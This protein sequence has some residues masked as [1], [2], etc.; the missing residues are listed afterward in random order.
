MLSEQFVRFLAELINGDKDDLYSYKSGPKIVLFFNQ[1]FGYEDVYQQGFPSRW[2]YT[3]NKIIEIL[4]KNNID[5]LFNI[6]LDKK[7][8]MR[9]HKIS[10][11]VAIEKEKIICDKINEM[12]IYEG[13]Y[14]TKRNGKYKFLKK[15]EDLEWIGGGGFADIYLQKSTGKIL[16]KLKEDFMLD[17]GIKSR[18]KREFN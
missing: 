14:L 13:Y 5:K 16:K 3:Y 6:I 11:E 8:I 4:N 7:Y 18:F 2:I 17:K 15:D 12:A 9:E 1:Y 10:E